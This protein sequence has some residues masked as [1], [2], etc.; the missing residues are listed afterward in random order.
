[1]AW[2]LKYKKRVTFEI[3]QE[4][5]QKEEWKQGSEPSSE[6]RERERGGISNPQTTSPFTL[7]LFRTSLIS[8]DRK[9]KESAPLSVGSRHRP[10]H[11]DSEWVQTKKKN[12]RWRLSA[13]DLFPTETLTSALDSQSSLCFQKQLVWF[14]SILFFKKKC[15]DIFILV[16]F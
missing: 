15:R 13:T 1:M 6:Q 10:G 7:C 12:T 16:Y 3:R 11:R 14:H 2:R 8:L 4:G 5:C 9:A